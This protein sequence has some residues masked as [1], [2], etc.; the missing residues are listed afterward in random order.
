MPET[1]FVSNDTS[2]QFSRWLVV[3]D[4]KVGSDDKIEDFQDSQM[5][6]TTIC[7]KRRQLTVFKVASCRIQ[8][9]ARMTKDENFQDSQAPET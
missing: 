2:W 6:E 9:L 7:L 8:E 1:K 5:P 4:T 3:G